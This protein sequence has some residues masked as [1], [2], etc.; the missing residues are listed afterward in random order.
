[1]RDVKPIAII[2]SDTHL[3]EKRSKYD[4]IIDN[5]YTEVYNAFNKAIETAK[6]NNLDFVVF[7]GDFFDSR[8]SQSKSLLQMAENIFKLF[9][10]NQIKLYIINGNHDMTSYDD[11]YSFI[12]PFKYHPYINHIEVS[13][14]V[15]I[16]G[17]NIALHFLSFFE[18]ERY[19]IELEKIKAKLNHSE[20]NILITHI[21]IHGALKNDGEKE[22]SSITF[23]M[24][25]E[26]DKVLIGHY[27]N[28]S[29]HL[30]NKIVYIGSALQHNFGEDNNKGI[31]VLDNKLHLRRV[32]T[33][34]KEYK[35][36]V[37]DV[38][39]IKQSD[40]QDL[41]EQ[42]ADAYQKITLVGD[43]NLIKAFDKSK[44]IEAG[45]KCAVK[46]DTIQLQE[47]EQ[48]VEQHSNQSILKSFTDFCDT[49]KYNEEEG[50]MWLNLIVK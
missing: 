2:L 31:V 29:S 12:S 16:T 7:A 27:H 24:F 18:N 4:A 37:V 30:N 49:N 47:V 40:I 13:E 43:I 45:I 23:N 33:D 5:N 1:M 14:T 21:G 26:F 39:D 3:F 34:F 8:K 38:A 28:Y 36:I 44:L 15:V 10:V 11:E 32:K 22:Q 19:I 48:R 20:K 50:L 42:Q 17:T 41:I 46:Q 6:S 25:S 9:E 35:N